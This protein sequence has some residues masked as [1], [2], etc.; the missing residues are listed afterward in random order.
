M[1][2]K[3]IIVHAGMMGI[4]AAQLYLMILAKLPPVIFWLAMQ[5]DK[6]S[7]NTTTI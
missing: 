6:T 2:Q 7:R 3:R 4:P 1:S 5:A